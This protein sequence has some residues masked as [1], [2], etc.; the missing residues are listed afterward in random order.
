MAG[1]TGRY[2]LGGDTPYLSRFNPRQGRMAHQL[3]LAFSVGLGAV[4][5]GILFR[6]P[7]DDFLNDKIRFVLGLGLGIQFK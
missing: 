3:G 5:P 4:R 6:V 1:I 2:L 7:I